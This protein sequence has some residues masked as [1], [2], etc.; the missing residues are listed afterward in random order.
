M[1]NK[2]S[3]HFFHVHHFIKS[4]PAVNKII[5]FI[6]INRNREFYRS[7]DVRPPFTYAS[8]IRQVSTPFLVRNKK[9]VSFLLLE[10]L[11]EFSWKQ[12][13]ISKIKERSTYL[14]MLPPENKND[15]EGICYL[16]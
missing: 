8:L 9:P 1:Y 2:V 11:N 10:W 7:A 4:Q 15:R 6:E 12:G 13:F 5:F 3:I 14:T 16:V